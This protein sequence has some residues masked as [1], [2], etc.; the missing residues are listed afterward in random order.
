MFML[1]DSSGSKEKEEAAAA[2][3]ETKDLSVKESMK[4]KIVVFFYSLSLDLA[5]LLSFWYKLLKIVHLF[6]MPCCSVAYNM[7]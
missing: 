7:F 6:S 4:G 5:V 2:A 3:E 1:Q